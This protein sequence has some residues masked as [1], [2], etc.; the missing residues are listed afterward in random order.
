M[1]SFF[2]L[3]PCYKDIILGFGW[4][5]WP[6]WGGLAWYQAHS[7][8]SLQE[9]KWIPPSPSNQGQAGDWGRS[10]VVQSALALASTHDPG[11]MG[12]GKPELLR[13][14]RKWPRR[15][16]FCFSIRKWCHACTVHS[17][18]RRGGCGKWMLSWKTEGLEWTRIDG[19]TKDIVRFKDELD[20]MKFI[21]KDF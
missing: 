18:E 15:S 3:Y 20:I 8:T 19:V 16:C 12:S 17:A 5:T 10:C 4:R 7:S 13:I 21:C 1:Q 6:P 2:K 14:S 11:P 9:T